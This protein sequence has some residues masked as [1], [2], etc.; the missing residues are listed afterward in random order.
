VGGTSEPGE[1]VRS[2]PIDASALFGAQPANQQLHPSAAVPATPAGAAAQPMGPT[3]KAAGP[4]SL[5]AAQTV[6]PEPSEAAAPA[7]PSAR[8]PEPAG[9]AAEVQP[10]EVHEDV[11][12]EPAAE[13]A[14]GSLPVE[15]EPSAPAPQPSA[16]VFEPPPE[17]APEPSR[18][19]AS[20]AYEVLGQPKPQPKADTT[21]AQAKKAAATAPPASGAQL[22]LMIAAVVAGLA[23]LTLVGSWAGLY[24]LPWQ[25]A[26]TPTQQPAEPSVQPST[27]AE[28][29][30]AP[31]T[32]AQAA[33]SA[34]Q[35][36]AAPAQPSAAEAPAQPFAANEKPPAAPAEPAPS[37][38]ARETQ[39][40]LE[41]ADR[42]S[43]AQAFA[44][45]I[46]EARDQLKTHHPATAEAL[47]RPWAARLPED[48]RSAEVLTMALLE[49]SKGAEALPFAEQIVQ[50]NP[51]RAM[52][53]VLLGDALQLTGDTAG[54]AAAWHE[55]LQIAPN[56]R[57][58]Q[59]RLRRAEAAKPAAAH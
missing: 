24:R 57:Q 46:R 26:P 2:A 51:K 9:A 58:A 21:T 33:P 59:K 19:S 5:S 32:A 41:A 47:I 4:S 50:K 11:I 45:Q 49:Q 18:P 12:S 3:S 27:R 28:P 17:P 30:A 20:S 53:R 22:G 42:G 39:S 37:D 35:A 14:S 15:V 29:A 7:A 25:S 52:Y 10:F 56:N 48:H 54:A 23:L 6:G 38:D 44:A 31:A 1:G 8:A 13:A 34:A 16:G 55:A 36:A 40:E 43:Q